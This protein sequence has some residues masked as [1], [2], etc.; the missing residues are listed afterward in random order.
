MSR[1]QANLLLLLVS[2]IWGSSFAAQ[3]LGSEHVSI[4]TFNTTRFALGALA[5]LP[6][7]WREWKKV[8]LP[9]GLWPGLLATGVALQCGSLLQ[10]MGVTYTSVT[11]AGFITGIY[12]P[13]VPIIGYLVLRH[14]PHPVIWPAAALSLFGTWLLSGGGGLDFAPGDLWVL[15]SSIFWACHVLLV[16]AMAVRSGAPTVVA[17]IQFAFC[18]IVGSVMTAGFDPAPFAGTLEALP[19]IAYVGFLSV[20]LA[21]TLQSVTQR[22]TSASDAAIILSGETVFSA[23]GGVLVMGETFDGVKLAGCAAILVAML[24]VQL[25]PGL[26]GQEQEQGA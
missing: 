1:L 25:V 19:E 6:L 20:G 10:Q 11:N 16:G 24:L 8:G 22:Y 26:I 9:K 2:V 3:K 7:A 23:V 18:A 13:L 17:F 12:V 14:R 21:F 15:V 5:V 4:L